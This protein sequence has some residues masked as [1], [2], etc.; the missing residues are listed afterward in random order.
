[1]VQGLSYFIKVSSAPD[2]EKKILLTAG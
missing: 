1:V 2:L